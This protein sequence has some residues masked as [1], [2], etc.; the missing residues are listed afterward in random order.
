[1]TRRI[2][3]WTFAAA[4]AVQAVLV[5]GLLADRAW[6]FAT[7]TEIRLPVVPVDPRDLF[8]GDYVVLNYSISNLDRSTLAGDGTFTAGE[9]IYVTLVRDGEGWRAAAIHHARPGEGTVLRG[10]V[11]GADTNCTQPCG[12]YLVDYGLEQFFVPEGAGRALETLRD[13]QHVSV[14]VAIGPDGRAALKRLL[15]D[16]TV[17][18]EDRI[19]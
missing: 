11:R 7:G 19:F 16:G 4:F 13:G 3:G 17:R 15:V 6:L 12:R 14:D 9:P 18:Y 2:P 5:A 10:I 1:M 8:R